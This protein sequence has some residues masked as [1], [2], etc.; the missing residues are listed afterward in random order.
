MKTSGDIESMETTKSHRGSLILTLFAT[1]ILAITIIGGCD[2]DDDVILVG[3]TIGTDVTWTVQNS[4]AGNTT[5][6][7][8]YFLNSNAG[9]AVGAGGTILSYKNSTWSALT[10]GVTGSLR[11]VQF[12][13]ASNGF[14]VGQNG[15]ILSTTDSGSTWTLDSNY[16]VCGGGKERIR[17]DLN[18]IF[19]IDSKNG[20]VVGDGGVIYNYTADSACIDSAV[21]ETTIFIDSTRWD[22][23]PDTTITDSLDTTFY[24]PDSLV[25]DT[26]PVNVIVGIPDSVRVLDTISD[27]IGYDVTAN[28]SGFFIIRDELGII[29]NFLQDLWD[30]YFV[31]A[32]NGWIV[33]NLGTIIHTD[34]AGATWSIQESGTKLP[35]RGVSFVDDMNGW[36]VGHDNLILHTSDGGVTWRR[37]FEKNGLNDHYI[38]VDFPDAS[39][40][41]VVNSQGEVYRTADGGLSWVRDRLGSG[42]TLTSLHFLTATSGWAVGYN[43]QIIHSEATE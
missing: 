12:T 40:G 31:D 39:N 20:W 41:W 7:S 9:W 21:L 24:W 25:V 43:G 33:G 14:V 26:I 17:T 32:N 36:A 35:L 30:V 3:P 37:Q 16:I 8:V 23:I 2:S 15:F 5:L 42:K 38:A 22:T 27:T 1:M 34:D 18:D 10:S 11:G 28:Q 6:N 19:F 29:V 13:S 4:G